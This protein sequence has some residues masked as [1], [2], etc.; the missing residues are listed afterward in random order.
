MKLTN[1]KANLENKLYI[2]IS[3]DDKVGPSHILSLELNTRQVTPVT[4]VVIKDYITETILSVN[5]TTGENFPEDAKSFAIPM[6]KNYI[7]TAIGIN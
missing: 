4:V 1:W 3:L 6:F 7:L 2:N 5:Y